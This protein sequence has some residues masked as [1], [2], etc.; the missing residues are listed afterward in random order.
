VFTTVSVNGNLTVGLNSGQDPNNSPMN[1]SADVNVYWT[2]TNSGIALTSYTPTFTYPTGAIMSG[3]TQATFY[4]ALYS[5]GAWTLLLPTNAGAGPYTSVPVAQTT[6]GDYVIGNITGNALYVRTDGN[7]NNDGVG[8]TASGGTHNAYATLAKAVAMVQA[9]ITVYI[10]PGTY[11]EI[12]A[13]AKTGTI[14]SHIVWWGDKEARYFLDKKAGYVRVTGCDVNEIGQ[15]TTYIISGQNYNDFWNLV[16]DGG[17]SLSSCYGFANGILN[18][19]NCVITAPNYAFNTQGNLYNCL[20]LHGVVQGATSANNCVSF[21]NFTCQYCY[22]CIS[23]GANG[24]FNG[25]T[26]CYNCTAFFGTYGFMYVHTSYNCT[27]VGCTYAFQGLNTYTCN[28]IKC[29]AIN[30][31]NTAA[32]YAAYPI[33]VSDIK[34][35]CYAAALATTGTL[36]GTPTEVGIE[37]Y[38]DIS[39]LLKLATAL[40]PDIFETDW[41]TDLHKYTIAGQTNTPLMPNVYGATL[42]T[43]VNDYYMETG[44]YNGALYYVNSAQSYVLFKSSTLQA[45]NWVLAAGTTP[46][47]TQTNYAW[48]TSFAG[49]Y[50]KVGTWTGTIA[51]NSNTYNCN[52]DFQTGGT[53]NGQN[54]YI[55]PFKNYVLFYSSTLQAG[56]WVVTSG[57]IANETATNYAYCATI[58][59]TYTNIGS[60]TGTIVNATYVPLVFSPNTDILNQ[61]R[62][63]GSVILDC[64]AFEYSTKS[65]DFSTYHTFAPSVKLA[66]AGYYP[67]VVPVKSGISKTISSWVTFNLNG[68]TNKPQM[69]I[70]SPE[71]ILTTNPITVTAAGSGGW[72]LLTTT[73]VPVADG[74]LNINLYAPETTA[75]STANFCDFQI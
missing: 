12:M 45:G 6:F 21:G 14:G 71:N 59:G 46:N 57:L 27:A 3:G 67:I 11:R 63:M 18:V 15:C 31:S 26:A 75:G 10:A 24:A 55:T 17:K 62:R 36:Y 8:Y 33:N 70:N 34:T 22:N 2:L 28:Y 39:K 48:F 5:S 16:V 30:C 65:L 19:Y 23:I 58:T 13:L 73:I 68:G 37:T 49:T 42:P 29:K 9:G 25:N 4:T 61:P 20:I 38:T 35:S 1:A 69:I 40:K 43:A 7:N 54:Y 41:S 32:G 64:G 60:Y 72:E 66:T 52:Q 51:V 74:M 56:K 53:Y 44:I 50:T 47:E